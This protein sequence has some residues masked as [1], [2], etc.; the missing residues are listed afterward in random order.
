[1]NIPVGAHDL[2]FEA[3]D[4]CGNVSN[5][6]TQITVHDVMSPT[7]ICNPTKLVS[8]VSN[9]TATVNASIF[10]NNSYDDCS[11]QIQFQARRIN[12]D[13]GGGTD[14]NNTVTFC[15]ADVGNPVEVELKVSDFSGNS[16]ICSS[17]VLVSDQFAPNITCPTDV[18]ISCGFD[19][20][21]ISVFGTIVDNQANRMP[22]I[23]NGETVGLDGIATD[24][25]SV[26]IE[27]LE[28]SYDINNCGTGSFTRFFLATDPFG[29]TAS[30]IQNLSLIHI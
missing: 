2:T 1:M 23:I 25:C 27:E 4:V 17:T 19:Y 30:C 8:L 28:T 10:N 20:S 15:C 9:G 12:D 11:N 24:N 26:N 6:I 16:N 13:C 5:C 29:K 3:S 22:I 21:N 7:V 14:W 18:Q